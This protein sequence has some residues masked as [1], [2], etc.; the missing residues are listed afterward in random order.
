[1]SVPSTSMTPLVGAEGRKSFVHCPGCGQMRLVWFK[2][3][4]PDDARTWRAREGYVDYTAAVL[5]P[6][7]RAEAMQRAAEMDQMGAAAAWISC[8]TCGFDGALIH[9]QDQ[10]YREADRG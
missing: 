7:Q 8:T 1:M 9:G 10:T 4:S 2:V 6:D 5:P 3:M